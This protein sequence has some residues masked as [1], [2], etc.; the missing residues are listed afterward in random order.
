MDTAGMAIVTICESVILGLQGK[1]PQ[2]FTASRSSVAV[3]L[4]E[5]QATA[6]HRKLE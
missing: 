3:I 2:R 1:L 6:G 5:S 4:K